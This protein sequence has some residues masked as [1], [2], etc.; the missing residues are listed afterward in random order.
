M[1]PQPQKA[2]LLPLVLLSLVALIHM[3]NARDGLQ[4]AIYYLCAVIGFS[5]VFVGLSIG[6]RRGQGG[7]T[8]QDGDA[9]R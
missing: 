7:G 5:A 8:G 4:D 6:G 2:W 3:L 9:P 1:I